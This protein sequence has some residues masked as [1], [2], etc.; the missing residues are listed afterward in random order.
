MTGPP[1]AVADRDGRGARVH[2]EQAA[3]R[4]V[5]ESAERSALI[6]QMGG[7][8]GLVDSGLPALIFVTV[9]VLAGLRPAVVSAVVCGVGVLVLRLVR[10]QSVQHAVS[11]FL[12]LALAAFIAARTG[13]AE[14]FFLPGIVMNFVYA[15]ALVASVAVRRPLVGLAAAALEGRPPT[16][17]ED[18][19]VR[20]VYARATIGWA[21]Y[22]V[23]RA[24]ISLALYDA[25]TAVGL[26]LFKLSGTPTMIL[27]VVATVA[28]TRRARR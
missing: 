18:D 12:G 3:P 6:E 25:G 20:R 27:A 15:T 1:E 24:V 22:F 11:G 7:V 28:Y 9:N 21:V 16:W 19:A 5:P 2:P 4:P 10:R 14:G 13:R 17:R 8:R 26:L 23:V